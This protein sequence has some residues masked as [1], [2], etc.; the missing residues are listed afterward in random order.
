MAVSEKEL[1]MSMRNVMKIIENG[2][3]RF[4]HGQ[5]IAYLGWRGA[6]AF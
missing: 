1:I 5:K 2:I 6:V 3:I 4:C